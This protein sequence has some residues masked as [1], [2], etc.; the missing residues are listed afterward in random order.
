ME[1]IKNPLVPCVGVTF[2]TDAYTDSKCTLL[3]LIFVQNNMFETLLGVINS[4]VTY[5]VTSCILL[6]LHPTADSLKTHYR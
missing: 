5:K 3:I 2:L 1:R 4:S 6:N